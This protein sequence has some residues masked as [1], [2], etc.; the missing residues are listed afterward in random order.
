MNGV[1]QVGYLQFRI[2]PNSF[3]DSAVIDEKTLDQAWVIKARDYWKPQFEALEK[4]YL[5]IAASV[6]Q[7]LSR[8]DHNSETH[9]KLKEITDSLDVL[10]R[11]NKLNKAAFGLVESTR[12]LLS[13]Q[14]A[15]ALADMTDA[16]QLV[17]AIHSFLTVPKAGTAT[18]AINTTMRDLGLKGIRECFDIMRRWDISTTIA[19]DL[20][21]R[22]STILAYWRQEGAFCISPPAS[23][24][25]FAPLINTDRGFCRTPCV[26]FSE[27]G[28]RDGFDLS[29]G[30]D[31]PN[32][33][34][35]DLTLRV[36][37]T[38]T[39][40]LTLGGLDQLVIPLLSEEDELWKL[41]KAA[42]EVPGSAWQARLKKWFAT[43][44]RSDLPHESAQSFQTIVNKF[45]ETFVEAFKTSRTSDGDMPAQKETPEDQDLRL[46]RISAR[47]WVEIMSGLASLNMELKTPL[48]AFSLPYNPND[49]H[50]LSRTTLQGAE[51]LLVDATDR[52]FALVATHTPLASKDGKFIFLRAKDGS[53]ETLQVLYTGYQLIETKRSLNTLLAF[54][55]RKDFSPFEPLSDFMTYLRFHLGDAL[56]TSYLTRAGAN[57]LILAK[58]VELKANSPF[59]QALSHVSKQDLLKAVKACKLIVKKRSKKGQQINSTRI[60]ESGKRSDMKETVWRHIGLLDELRTATQVPAWLP[61]NPTPAPDVANGAQCVRDLLQIFVD[62][63]VLP[64]IEAFLSGTKFTTMAKLAGKHQGL[65]PSSD[66]VRALAPLSKAHSFARLAGTIAEAM[67]EGEVADMPPESLPTATPPSAQEKQKTK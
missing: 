22:R 27:D 15:A 63:K 44:L 7:A 41:F 26:S 34:Q 14:E 64:L 24:F 49:P 3:I 32:E 12:C 59:K 30:N 65:F 57:L 33:F 67:K 66:L 16:R 52:F 53:P 45:L 43:N 20:K 4:D 61:S 19:S 28:R 8:L 17:D 48:P 54:R 9:R 40:L 11:Q 51:K 1:P 39:S 5:R 31:S 47:H 2:P 38:D 6:S 46:Q 50:D 25:E 10:V 21:T 58:S 62:F 42:A 56:F 55:D 29:L 35:S 13:L 60:P 36:S 18:A 23:S 37:L